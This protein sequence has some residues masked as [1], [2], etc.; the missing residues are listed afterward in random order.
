MQRQTSKG[1]VRKIDFV[2]YSEQKIRQAVAAAGCESPLQ[3]VAVCGG[4]LEWP[5]SW[6]KVIDIERNKWSKDVHG[7][8][9]E[10][11]YKGEDSKK[12]CRELSISDSTRRK[13][14][15]DIRQHASL[16]ATQLGLIKHF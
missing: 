3:K 15:E 12:T 13:Y 9:L 4:W 14:L 10:R 5:E 16:V 7:E 11:R 2:F 6:L 8:V 1:Y